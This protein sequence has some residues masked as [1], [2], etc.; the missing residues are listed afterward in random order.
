MTLFSQ[1]YFIFPILRRFLNVKI[2]ASGQLLAADAKITDT[3]TPAKYGDERAATW[4]QKNEQATPLNFFRRF[5]TRFNADYR[6]LMEMSQK[7]YPFGSPT[8]ERS[9]HC[10]FRLPLVHEVCLVDWLH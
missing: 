6:L 2:V 8:F 3:A 4:K 1:K 10:S 7:R 9:R 5:S